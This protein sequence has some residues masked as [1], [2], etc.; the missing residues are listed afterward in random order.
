MFIV[1]I[2]GLILFILLTYEKREMESFP[3]ANYSLVE[4]TDIKQI[5]P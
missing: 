1:G 2:M 4:K 3:N 5:I